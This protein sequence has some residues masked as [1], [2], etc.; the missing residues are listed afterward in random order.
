MTT[1]ERKPSYERVLPVPALLPK[2]IL[3][4]GGRGRLA[5]ALKQHFSSGCTQLTSFSRTPGDGHLSF[6]PLFATSTLNTADALLHLAWSTVPLVSEQHPGIEGR[7]DLPLLTKILETIAALPHRDRLHFVFFSSGGTVYGNARS[8]QPSR[9]TDECLPV[10]SYGRAKL[11]AERVIQ[12]LGQRHGITYTIL[13]ISNPYGF[14]MPLNKPQGVIPFILQHAREGTPVTLW[15]DG[16]ARK[17]FIYH[18]DFVS[19]L[20]HVLRFRPIGVFNISAGQSHSIR[21]VIGLVE[22]TL[23]L[24]IRV[25]QVPA[26]PWDV[27]DSLLAND[28]LRDLVGWTPAIS[29]IEG[30]RRTSKL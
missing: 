26:Y 9:E 6:D 12:E 3:V 4:T 5:G 29:L 25:K 16:S 11:A 27:H 13:R 19:A 18:T 21:E 14:A 1:E 2:H 22:Q 23:G 20:E 24:P 15:G 30:I 7:E 28:K 17:D 8:N 10:G